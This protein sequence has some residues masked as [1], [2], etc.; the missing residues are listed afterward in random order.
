MKIL[1]REIGLRE[2]T[3][4]AEQVR[5]IL[6]AEDYKAQARPLADTQMELKDRVGTVTEKIRELPNAEEAFR[7]EIAILTRV[8]E[9]MKEAAFLLAIPQ[10]GPGTI[11]AETEAIELLLQTKRIN[12]KGGG[13]GGGSSPGG[14]GSGDTQEAALALIG[15]GSERNAQ[16]RARDVEMSTGTTGRELPVEFRSGLDAYFSNLEADG[17]SSPNE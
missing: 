3:R 10:T 6:E 5:A 16:P 14:G 4:A 2:E 7:I 12:P 9:V 1:E 17:P 11:A 8:E 13:G 15:A